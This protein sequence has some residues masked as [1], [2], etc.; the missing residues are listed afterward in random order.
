[1]SWR[2]SIRSHETAIEKVCNRYRNRRT[3]HFAFMEKSSSSIDRPLV[4]GS[5]TNQRSSN[6]P[7]GRSAID[8]HI[9][10]DIDFQSRIPW[11]HPNRSASISDYPLSRRVDLEIDRRHRS[12]QPSKQSSFAPK[13]ES[14]QSTTTRNFIKKKTIFF[15]SRGRGT[16]SVRGAS[17]KRGHWLE[18][19]ADYLNEQP[20]RQAWY[21]DGWSGLNWNDSIKRNMNTHRHSAIPFRSAAGGR[22][23]F[24]NT[25]LWRRQDRGRASV[26]TRL[27]PSMPKRLPFVFFFCLLLFY[28]QRNPKKRKHLNPQSEPVADEPLIIIGH[29]NRRSEKKK[30]DNFLIS[31]RKGCWCM[32]RNV[33]F[34]ENNDK[35]LQKKTPVGKWI[36][37]W[38]SLDAKMASLFVWNSTKPKKK[39]P[40][41]ESVADEPLIITIGS[42]N[43]LMPSSWKRPEK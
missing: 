32:K 35:M 36:W 6:K 23:R 33:V 26:P 21:Q 43:W 38:S 25:F 13:T 19:R 22:N 40:Q 28:I 3:Y 7:E 9:D 10:A 20:Q 18:K 34:V 31:N 42:S 17:I 15:C 37:T 5:S 29:S 39:I 12:P 2:I 30:N 8:G 16:V 4:C 1:M 41:S 27:R 11:L 24:R 14:P